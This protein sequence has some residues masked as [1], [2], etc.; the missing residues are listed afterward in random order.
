MYPFSFTSASMMA[1]Y[2]LSPAH[3]AKAESTATQV[4]QQNKSSDQRTVRK[5]AT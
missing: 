5:P 2:T 1:V 4:C 3:T